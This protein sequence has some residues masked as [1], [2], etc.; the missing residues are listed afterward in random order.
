[1]RASCTLPY[2]CSCC[3]S[4]PCE[5]AVMLY[6]LYLSK[7]ELQM[8][9]QG[10]V[11]EIT[12]GS[13][14]IAWDHLET[15]HWAEMVHFLIENFPGRKAWDVT[16]DIFA[17]MNQDN[18]SFLVR[19]E[20]ND[21]LPT[22]EP[23]DM[24]PRE[25]QMNLEEESGELQ[26]YKLHVIE[27]YLP[28]WNSTTWPRNQ[29]DFLYQDVGRHETYLP[30]LFLPKRPQ[31]RQ[32]K[33]VVIQG[34]PGVGKTTLAKRIMMEWA[35]N[36]FYAHKLWYVVYFHCEEVNQA[37][38]QS[39]LEL[40][41]N[42]WP[43]SQALVSKIMSSPDQLLLLFDGFEEFPTTFIEKPDKLSDDC[44]QK[45]PG[46]VILSS[47]LSKRMLPEATLL[48]MI[49][50]TSWQV[51]KSMLKCPSRVALPGFDTREKIKYFRTYFGN[52]REG[53]AALSFALENT[54]LFSMCQAPAV[55]WVVCS[56][57]K[58]LVERSE[59]LTQ[60][61]P[62]A[63]TVFV[64]YL[65]GLFATGAENLSRKMQQ[66][67]LESLCHLASRGM[68]CRKW[69]FNTEDLRKAKV[70]EAGVAAL[71]SVNILRR[72]E[73]KED[74]YA[75]TLLIFQEFF[76]ALFYVLCFPQRLKTFHA[77][78]RMDIRRLVASP[79]GN[80]DLAHM[81]LFLFG[82]LNEVCMSVVAQSF[83]CRPSW[84]NKKKLFKVLPWLHKSHPLSPCCGVPQLFCCLHEIQ[85]E[86]FVRQALDGYHKAIL[87]IN[88]D[89]DIQVSAFCLKYCRN[90]Q[91]ME[92]TVTLNFMNGQN[93]S[94]DFHDD[95]E[96]LASDKL[97]DWWQDLCSVFTTNEKLEVLAVTDSVI[98]S[99]VVKILADALKHPQCKLQKLLLQ[100][101]DST[102]LSEDFTRVLIKNQH[103]RSLEIRCMEVDRKAMELL[104]LAL[105][106]PQCR[107][108]CLRLE[109]CW[110][111]PRNRM[112]LTSNLQGNV[113]LK[114]LMLR[115]SSLENFGEHSLS[116]AWLEKLSLENC[117]LTELTC[118]SL[119]SCLRRSERLTHLSL[120]ENALKDDG[121][122]HIWN[123]LEHLTCPLQ[124]LVLRKC[125]LTSRCCQDIAS[126]L[127]NSKALRSLDLGL[128]SLGDDGILL[129][130]GALR[131][132]DCKLQ[133]LE[134]EKCLF[135]SAC[136]QSMA[137]VLCS[138]KTLRYLDLSQNDIGVNGI[139]T[140]CG[141][142]SSQ[143]QTEE[144]I[145]EKKESGE[146]DMLPRLEGPAVEGDFLKIVQDWNS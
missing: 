141:A 63:T 12:S 51:C 11:N 96:E 13:F 8:F 138:N 31:G 64:Q 58:Q 106:Y 101:V 108:Q 92:L 126:V 67:Q 72:V 73:S 46:S 93:S 48:I 52:T 15:A 81:G 74:H 57:L 88:K 113:H 98:E 104:G 54:I 9:K 90:L 127:P 25:P 135:T 124:R 102:L 3:S 60:V 109:D 120:A 33:T 56:C 30:C 47:L 115:K 142:F 17:K 140:L 99:P 129:L 41:E 7:E 69:V 116:M 146:V 86:D 130:C 131:H 5:D 35:G 59:N 77:L 26:K 34:V 19:R 20:L 40:L 42:K 45:L 85:E 16:R 134:L 18:M 66:E 21:I 44:T 10:L 36:K 97:Y 145:L 2:A 84:C 122:R 29:R 110:T 117:D 89:T 139:L 119:V 118:K 123:T 91:E 103:L 83:R 121:A 39:F 112:D 107:L 137:S 55:C 136:C 95:S 38:G 53:R 6:M 70:D 32:P 87:R 4:S 1:M 61:C 105:K 71:L 133:I 125:D 22:L 24:H 143:K 28:I 37:A 62:N 76:A 132:P 43:E 114:T 82:L 144:V 50:P 75:F 111:T 94:F 79:R 68:W 128:N 49:R 23:E 65:S 14:H 80:N 27:K 78:T 100:R